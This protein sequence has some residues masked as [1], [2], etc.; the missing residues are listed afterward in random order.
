[1][2][3]AKQITEVVNGLVNKKVGISYVKSLLAK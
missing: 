1:V 2:L 3:A